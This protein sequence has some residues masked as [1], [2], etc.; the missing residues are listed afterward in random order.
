MW[1]SGAA[2]ARLCATGFV[3]R[4]PT[5]PSARVALLAAASAFAGS[6]PIPVLPV[7][8]VRALRGALA[9][10]VLAQH[11][12]VLT[13]EARDVFADPG[14]IPSRGRGLVRDTVQYLASRMFV[15]FAPFGSIAVPARTAY[16]VL[17]FGR[18]LERYV[19]L[20]RGKSEAFGRTVRVERAEAEHVRSMIESAALK[21]LTPSLQTDLLPV[22]EAPEDHRGMVDRFLDGAILGATRL[23]DVVAARLDAA[24]DSLA[25]PPA[26]GE[27]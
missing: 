5:P 16:E 6:F 7:R 11:G 15:R 26:E 25:A 2:R 19:E 10:D 1:Q 27:S 4:P 21:A 22:R 17:A 13:A 3:M 9:H 8:I 23:P 20:F 12:L 18:L 24:F 14:W